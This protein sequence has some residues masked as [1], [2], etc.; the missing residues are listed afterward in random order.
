MRVR[1]DEY[2]GVESRHSGVN[3]G[4]HCPSKMVAILVDNA[5]AISTSNRRLPGMGSNSDGAPEDV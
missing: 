4:I 3:V 1:N 5:A 2:S